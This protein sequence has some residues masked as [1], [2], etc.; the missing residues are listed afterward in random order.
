[1]AEADESDG[2]FLVYRPH[3]ALVTNVDAD[4]LDV[5]GSEEA[6]RAAFAEF[7]GTIDAGRRPRALHRRSRGRRPRR[8]QPRIA[9][10]RW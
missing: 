6:Y 1:M 3:A 4:H 9:G 8:D 7:V 5:W 10:C 2:A